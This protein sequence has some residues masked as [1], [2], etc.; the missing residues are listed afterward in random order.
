[1]P[2]EE[3]DKVGSRSATFARSSRNLSNSG[4]RAEIQQGE[5]LVE[6]PKCCQLEKGVGW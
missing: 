2:A 5:R 4:T 6:K 3:L 1:M